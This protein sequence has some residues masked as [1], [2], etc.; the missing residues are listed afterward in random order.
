MATLGP[1][2]LPQM[3]HLSSVIC[4]NTTLNQI[5]D[6]T[7]WQQIYNDD[8]GILCQL[9]Q[10]IQTALTAGHKLSEI[11]KFTKSSIIGEVNRRNWPQIRREIWMERVRSDTTGCDIQCRTSLDGRCQTGWKNAAQ[12]RQQERRRMTATVFSVESNNS[13]GFSYTHTQ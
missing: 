10:H 12:T 3:S 6:S 13:P 7:L 2:C 9:I 5:T 11:K 1:T 4:C 8:S